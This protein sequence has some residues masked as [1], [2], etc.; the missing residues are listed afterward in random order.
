MEPSMDRQQQARERQARNLIERHGC[1]LIQHG[2]VWRVVGPGTDVL[3]A[4]LAWL[5]VR[6]FAPLLVRDE[7]A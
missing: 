6:D 3:I 2:R 7:E 1:R 5:S 4:D